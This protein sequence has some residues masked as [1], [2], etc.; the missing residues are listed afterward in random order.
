[1]RWDDVFSD[2]QAEFDEALR[3]EDEAE[4]AELVRA[5]VAGISLADRCRARRGQEL[6]VRLCDGS[7][8]SGLVLEANRAWLLLGA[9]ERRVL[10]PIDAVVLAWPL[11]SAAPEPGVVEARA[12]LGRALRALAQNGTEVLV[13]TVAGDHRG[14]LARVGADHCDVITSQAV[15]SV[16]WAGLLSVESH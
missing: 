8:R 1:M 9:G 13:R 2:L 3:S 10:V 16:A 4:I 6:T 11:A 5:E 15:I 12:G 7:D 14:R